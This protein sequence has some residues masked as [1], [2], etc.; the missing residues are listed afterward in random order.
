MYVC[1]YV[2]M[3][4]FFSREGLLLLQISGPFWPVSSAARSS[5]RQRPSHRLCGFLL[6]GS[7]VRLLWSP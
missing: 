7:P 1:M 6:R 2:C 3:Y 5:P 4:V